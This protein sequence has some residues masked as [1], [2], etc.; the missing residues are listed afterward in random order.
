[1]G[2]VTRTGVGTVDIRAYGNRKDF[3]V[4][5][6][7]LAAGMTAKVNGKVHLDAPW[8]EVV[9]TQNAD[10]IF[11]IGFLPFLQLQVLSGT[12]VAT[13]YTQE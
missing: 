5:Q 13:L 10:A 1:M 3:M 6:I 2:Q 4:L 7:D 9:E 8:L 12:G 11:S